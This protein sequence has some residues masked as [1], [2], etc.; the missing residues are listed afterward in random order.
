MKK[1]EK[2]DDP[3]VDPSPNQDSEN[4]DDPS[5]YP[6][7][8]QDSEKLDDPSVDLS[9]NQDSEKLDD[10][11]DPSSDPES[12]KTN[13]ASQEMFSTT[14]TSTTDLTEPHVDEFID[15]NGLFDNDDDEN[16]Q[17]EDNID[18]EREEIQC[19]TSPDLN[20]LRN[21]LANSG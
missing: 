14:G 13:V 3:P 20:L 5:V 9:P 12:E 6:S 8:N 16:E 21:G 2:I 11:I 19:D 10:S 1:L 15:D 17:D 18:D 4:L 7:P